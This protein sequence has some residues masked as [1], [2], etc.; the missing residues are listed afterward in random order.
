MASKTETHA[1]I[2]NEMRNKW[3]QCYFSEDY[4]RKDGE[5]SDYPAIE[6]YKVANRLE[7]AHKREVAE[8]REALRE[9]INEFCHDCDKH[10][11]GKCANT[12]NSCFVQKW[13]KALEG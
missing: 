9:A 1:D 7:A 13:R 10:K 4:R 11:D 6:P 5:Y 12:P 2:I 8:L 3:A